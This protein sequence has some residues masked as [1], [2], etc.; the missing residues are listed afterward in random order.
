[1]LFIKAVVCFLCYIYITIGQKYTVQRKEADI[2][3]KVL[4]QG[5]STALNWPHLKTGGLR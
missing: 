3:V 2:R 5:R 1:M 4:N